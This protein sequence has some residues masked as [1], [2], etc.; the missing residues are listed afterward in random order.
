[1]ASNGCGFFGGVSW[2]WRKVSGQAPPFE[3][4]CHEHDLAYEQIESEADRK[5]ADGQ[6]RRCMASN[7]W[8]GL[9]R[10]FYAAVRAGGWITW[11]KR[12]M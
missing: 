6:F 4:C 11:I 1:M 10:L 9:G 12:R 8:P 2:L 5:W 3:L 7:G